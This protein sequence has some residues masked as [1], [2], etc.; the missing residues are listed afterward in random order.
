M[1]M[2]CLTGEFTGCDEEIAYCFH[3][4]NLDEGDVVKGC[5]Y[6]IRNNGE[7]YLPFVVRGKC[8]V[9]ILILGITARKNSGKL[10]RVKE[11]D[12][13]LP[14]LCLVDGPGDGEMRGRDPGKQS[15]ACQEALHGAAH[16]ALSGPPP[17]SCSLQ[18][19]QNGTDS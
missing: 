10:R 12:R 15:G 9:D 11:P 2:E 19:S 8:P 7:Y 4:E 16:G 13:L 3:G 18:G 1:R 14:A 17:A 5:F 6:V